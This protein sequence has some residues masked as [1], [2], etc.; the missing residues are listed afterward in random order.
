MALLGLTQQFI[1]KT[2]TDAGAQQNRIEGLWQIILRAG[3]D[4]A[5][6]S[7]NFVERGTHD[8]R[9]VARLWVDFNCCRT[10]KPS[11]P[12]IMV[13]SR[14]TSKDPLRANSNACRPSVA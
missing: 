6:D 11:S 14:T 4:A 1:L 7:F 10:L 3:F 12:G 5:N 8:D 2:G 13:S 9:D